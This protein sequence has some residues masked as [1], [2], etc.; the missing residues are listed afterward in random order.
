MLKST[1]A[2]G[3]SNPVIARHY[4]LARECGATGGKLLGAGGG[5]F[6]LVFCR[7]EKQPAVRQALSDLREMKVTASRQG[8]T[9]IYDD[10]AGLSN[11]VAAARP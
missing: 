4:G 6:L 1:L 11:A 2:S 7:P 5:G 8:S 9:V 10:F 3:I